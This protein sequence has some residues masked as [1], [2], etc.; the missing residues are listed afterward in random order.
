MAAA[1]ENLLWNRVLT[2]DVETVSPAAAR[3][4]LA[5]KIKKPDIARFNELSGLAKRGALTE[6]QREELEGF[7]RVGDFISLLHAKARVALKRAGESKPR[8]KSA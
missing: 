5:I 1:S 3:A 8:R 6:A 7:L 2:P 4:L